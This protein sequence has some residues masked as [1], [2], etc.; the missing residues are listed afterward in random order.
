M[1]PKAWFNVWSNLLFYPDLSLLV[2]LYY[3]YTILTIIYRIN[4][5]YGFFKYRKKKVTDF[6]IVYRLDNISLHFGHFLSGFYG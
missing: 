6:I 1:P 5:K 3:Y 4:K 2:V